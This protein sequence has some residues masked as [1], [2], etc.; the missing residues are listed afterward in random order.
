MG[1]RTLIVALLGVIV[2]TAVGCGSGD[3]NQGDGTSLTF[4][5]AEDNPDRVKATQADCRSLSAADQHHGQAGRDQRGPTSSQVASASAAGTPPDVLAAVSLGFVHAS[6]ADGITDPDA[7]TAVIDTLGPETFSRQGLSLVEV[8]GRPAA[9]PSDSWTQL[10]VYRK[11]LFDQAGLAAPTTFEAIRTAAATL[12][13]GGWQGSSRPPR[14]ATPSPSRP[15]STWRWPT[16]ANSST[17]P[18]PSPWPAS[19]VS[20]PSTSTST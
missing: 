12:T 10:L 9:V 20:T 11:D 19:P 7:A 8:N 18:A 5:T 14:R 3:G 6:A 15:S 17:R 16:T 4:W 1:A 13:G 2:L